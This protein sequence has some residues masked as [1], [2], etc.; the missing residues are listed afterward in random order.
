MQKRRLKVL[1]LINN[2]KDNWQ[3]I[4]KE[5]PYCL[6][7][8]ECE[9]PY[10]YAKYY[11]LSY[12][13]IESD[14]SLEICQECR[15]LIIRYRPFV[16]SK[17]QIIDREYK[18]V[19]IPFYKFFNYLEPNAHKLQGNL[20]VQEKVDGCFNYSMPVMLSDGT[21]MSIGKIVNQKLNVE[22]LSYNQ[23][24]K[25]IEPKKV[26]GWSKK[27]TDKD[28][29]K[30]WLTID[31]SGVGA[32]L[33]GKIPHSL[34]MNVTLNHLIFTK[35]KD[36]DMIETEAKN[37]KIGDS[38]FVPIIKTSEIEKQ[39]IL[40]GILG[41]MSFTYYGEKYKENMK[42]IKYSHARQYKEY[43]E[44]KDKLLKN[45][46]MKSKDYYSETAYGKYKTTSQSLV[47]QG[48]TKLYNICFKNNKK[49][50]SKEWLDNIGWLG[51]A[52]WY[53][54]D[55]SLDKGH[56]NNSIILH[57]NAYS[58]DEHLIM[59]EYFKDKGINVN[60][61]KSRKYY[62]LYF[63]SDSSEFIWNKIREY[64]PDIMQYKLPKRHQGYFDYNIF[65]INAK[66]NIILD[67]RFITNIKKGASEVKFN[68][69][70]C[71]YDI[72]VSDNHNYFCGGILVHNSLMKLWYDFGQWHISTNGTID[73]RTANLQFQTNKYNTYRDL[74]N[75]AAIKANLNTDNLNK[76][77]TYMFELV[78]PYNRI[79]VP[80]NDIK[81]YHIGTRN[82]N[83][84]EELE[85][86]LGIDKPKQYD[87][88]NIPEIINAASILPFDQEGYVVVDKDYN[89]NK[90]KSPAYLSV[91][92][93][94]GQFN[95]INYRVI[96]EIILNNG[97]DDVLSYYPEYKEHFNL[98][99]EKYN[100][101]INKIQNNINYYY[102]MKDTEFNAENQQESKKLFAKWAMKQTNSGILFKIYQCGQ[103][104]WINKFLIKRGQDGNINKSVL[105]NILQNMNVINNDK[106]E[107]IKE[108]EE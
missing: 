62:Y 82:N 96:L 4:L 100:G 70:N 40:G 12:N 16:V 76:D 33:N 77:Y 35:N 37:L 8:N 71:K 48:I 41:D 30:E 46:T 1:E 31:F 3:E 105:N 98:V 50:I 25:I 34:P 39:V 6:K 104:D 13:M 72:E 85:F 23:N 28:K 20:K 86:D 27:Q 80:Y 45:L 44:Y 5:K 81:I 99:Q 7:I 78:S 68:G 74:F 91:H 26:I 51:F 47:N 52:I 89:R 97:Q 69:G 66:R 42:G 21:K 60:I 95:T 92:Y 58:Y 14:M 55:G 94:R 59:Q 24:T 64:I 107:I 93:L 15:G 108:I 61:R 36:G 18:A 90:I 102:N 10:E 38:V 17:T 32:I 43:V 54:D 57:T 53:M 75:E 29:N 83:T 11:I 22:V 88:K 101:Y 79:V 56:K 106:N 49:T 65:E 2:N 103:E 19:C 73:A 9:G 84:L 67:E 87:L 63:T